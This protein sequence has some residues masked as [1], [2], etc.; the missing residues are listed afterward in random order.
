[1]Q[2]RRVDDLLLLCIELTI[3]SSNVLLDL[4]GKTKSIYNRTTIV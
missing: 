2:G 1:M 4:D 3:V